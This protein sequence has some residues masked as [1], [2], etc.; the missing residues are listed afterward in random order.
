MKEAPISVLHALFDAAMAVD[1]V[2]MAVFESEH[3]N[4]PEALRTW[5]AEHG[6]PLD[7]VSIVVGAFGEY[8]VIGVKGSHG[9]AA[10]SVH[11]DAKARRRAAA[12]ARS[13]A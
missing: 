1:G 12:R 2:M 3:E 11:V 6:K 13:T 9:C 10:I 7:R 5:C 4:A 8:E